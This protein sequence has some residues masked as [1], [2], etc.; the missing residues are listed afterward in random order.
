MCKDCG[1]STAMHPLFLGSQVP[2]NIVGTI[3]LNQNTT[4]KLSV[5]ESIFQK[6]QNLA[7]ENRLAFKHRNLKVINVMSSPGSGKTTLLS[8]LLGEMKNNVRLA[9]LVGDQETSID[10]DRYLQNGVQAVQINTHAACHL[11]AQRIQSHLEKLPETLQLLIIE[12]V[13]NL[14]CPAVFDLGEELKVALLST[15]EGEEKPL[16]YPVLFHDADLILLTKSDLLLVLD[17]NL[18]L[19]MKNLRSINTK[20]P[21]I[22][23]STKTGQGIAE[24]KQI[25][26][27]QLQLT[28]TPDVLSHSRPT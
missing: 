24:I 8:L 4:R 7:A 16:K 27:T 28:E 17:Y 18:D 11:D 21:I 14:V 15:P 6:N 22:L 9:V 10:A 20:A 19:V 23:C 12:N 5:E 1:C 13:G 3:K 25:L 2:P 26:R